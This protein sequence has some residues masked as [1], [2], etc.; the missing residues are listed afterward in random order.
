MA[1]DHRLSNHWRVSN[2]KACKANEVF[3]GEPGLDL[4]ICWAYYLEASAVRLE[5]LN[6]P[7]SS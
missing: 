4:I 3:R 1:L 2:L 5:G 7:P 6:I